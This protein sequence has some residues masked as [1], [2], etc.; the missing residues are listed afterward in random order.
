MGLSLLCY[1]QFK[2]LPMVEERMGVFLGDLRNIYRFDDGTK[3]LSKKIK[4]LYLV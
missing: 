1:P 3:Q 4:S 2:S